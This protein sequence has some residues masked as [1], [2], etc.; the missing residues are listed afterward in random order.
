[1]NVGSIGIGIGVGSGMGV[2]FNVGLWKR[3]CVSRL[4]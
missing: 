1:M 3:E 4:T 2:G